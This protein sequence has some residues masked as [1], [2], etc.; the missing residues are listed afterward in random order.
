MSVLTTTPLALW[1][2][3]PA[4]FFAGL[5]LASIPIII[6]ILNFIAGHDI[7]G[8]YFHGPRDM[9]GRII[10]S[11]AAAGTTYLEVQL[12]ADPASHQ[13]IVSGEYLEFHPSL[14]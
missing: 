8:F 4:F 9:P 1:A 11:S 13:L 2:A 10:V 5:A 3:T 12:L 6:H 14:S 7:D